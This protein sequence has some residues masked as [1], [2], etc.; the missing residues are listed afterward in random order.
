MPGDDRPPFV[1]YPAD[2]IKNRGNVTP[3]TMAKIQR[4]MSFS[5]S[6]NVQS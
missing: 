3:A 2:V 1:D 5:W 6:V 4:V